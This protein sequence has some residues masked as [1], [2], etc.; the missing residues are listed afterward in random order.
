MPVLT[1][2]P[3]TTA[4]AYGATPAGDGPLNSTVRTIPSATAASTNAC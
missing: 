2:T 4:F 3:S 1:R